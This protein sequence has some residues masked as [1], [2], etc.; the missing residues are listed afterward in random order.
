MSEV[1]S[2]RCTRRANQT[3]RRGYL[4]GAAHVSAMSGREGHTFRGHRDGSACIADGC[5]SSPDEWLAGAW[6][7]HGTAGIQPGAEAAL[8]ALR[9]RSRRLTA[10]L[11]YAGHAL[12]N[13]I[14]LTRPVLRVCFDTRRTGRRSR[15]FIRLQHCVSWLYLYRR[16]ISGRPVPFVQW[17]GARL[18]LQGRFGVFGRSACVEN[19]LERL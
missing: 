12:R 9:M 5:V 14:V 16:E 17:E 13:K 6:R 19:V 8:A 1:A 18:T 11:G 4:R 10:R 3:R 7:T 2:F 15:L